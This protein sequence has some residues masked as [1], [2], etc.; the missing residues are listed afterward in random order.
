[1]AYRGP[2][3]CSAPGVSS[4]QARPR[5]KIICHYNQTVLVARI[6]LWESEDWVAA[7]EA[8]I[9]SVATEFDPDQTKTSVATT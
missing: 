4:V 9:V 3:T 7:T 8:T 6:L 5:E 2:L 1:M